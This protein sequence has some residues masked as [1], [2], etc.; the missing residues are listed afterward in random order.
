M[1]KYLGSIMTGYAA[2]VTLCLIMFPIV[3]AIIILVS[4]NDNAATFVAIGCGLC[5]A[6][7]VMYIK[8]VLRELYSWGYFEEN[9]VVVRTWFLQPILISY[10]KCRC[11]GIMYYNHTIG[12]SSIGTK[13]F[14]IFLSYDSFDEKYRTN[15]NK[16]MVTPT[17]IK[18]RFSVDM[19]EYLAGILPPKLKN[20]LIRDYC[21]YIQKT[22]DGLRES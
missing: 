6:I 7:L 3:F 12:S 21:K 9:Q 20:S 16:Y 13:H 14:Y 4:T 5:S 19:L 22:G 15:A 17:Q 10:S 1:K 8:G 2:L 18:V 11:C